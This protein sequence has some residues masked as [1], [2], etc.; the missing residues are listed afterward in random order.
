MVTILPTVQ[1]TGGFYGVTLD[2]CQQN[3]VA[4]GMVMQFDGSQQANVFTFV[5]GCTA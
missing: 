2:S 4:H 1:D 5:S 3:L